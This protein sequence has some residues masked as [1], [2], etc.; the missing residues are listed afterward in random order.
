MRT[1]PRV[2]AAAA[3]TQVVVAHAAAAAPVA[4]TPESAGDADGDE[5]EDP[6]QFDAMTLRHL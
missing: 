6:T 1:D 4:A 3:A 2:Q 5:A